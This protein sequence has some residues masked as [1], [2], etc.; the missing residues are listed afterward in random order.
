MTVQEALNVLVQVVEQ[1][2]RGLPS[3]QRAAA[4]ALQVIA[5]T[6]DSVE[7]KKDE[8]TESS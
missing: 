2:F 8:P 4:L 5:K 7:E 6:V 3:E 1:Y